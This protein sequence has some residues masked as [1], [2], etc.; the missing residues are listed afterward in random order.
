VEQGDLLKTTDDG[1]TWRAITSYE[2]SWH[3]FRRDMHRLVVLPSDPD[4]LYLATGVGLFYSEDAGETWEHMTTP[5]FHVGYPDPLFLDPMDEKTIYM[6]GASKA[7]N[8]SWT[9]LRSARPGI[10]KST[11]GGRNWRIIQLGLPEPILGNIEAVALQHSAEQGT[12]LYFGTAIGELYASEDAGESW[13]LLARGLPP[14]SKG[15]HYRRFLSDQER[16]DI[17]N[18]LRTFAAPAETAAP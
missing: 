18:K 1:A 3:Q 16:I 12:A 2:A 17:E 13:T 9:E 15:A 5:D 7:P 6:A 14:I 10:V 4:K 11:D 8:P